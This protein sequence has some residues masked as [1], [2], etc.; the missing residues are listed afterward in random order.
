M[1]IINE[2]EIY[3][4]EQLS[5]AIAE[6][7]DAS[8]YTLTE[9]FWGRQPQP[10]APTLEQAKEAKK[11]AIDGRTD[12]LIAGGFPY[13]SKMFSL[14][15]EAQATWLGMSEAKAYLTYPFEVSTKEGNAYNL[16]DATA[17]TMFFLTGV[18]AV[19]SYIASGRSL[20]VQ[21]NAATTV[22]EVDAIVDPR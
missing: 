10:P 6:M 18:N 11:M 4:E 16:A 22:A 20:K 13:D 15:I 8:K 17:V 19:K 21:V 3:T 9:L 1:I 14:S 5:A 7:D 2:I 12:E